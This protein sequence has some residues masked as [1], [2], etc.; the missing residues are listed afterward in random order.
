MQPALVCMSYILLTRSSPPA[1]GWTT[2]FACSG[3]GF[4]NRSRSKDK[5]IKEI[6]I[7]RNEGSIREDAWCLID[8]SLRSA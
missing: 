2:L 6:D 1:G 3:K 7:L 8:A 5:W 4:E